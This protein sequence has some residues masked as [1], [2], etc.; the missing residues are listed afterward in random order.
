MQ[1]LDDGAIDRAL[2]DLPDW[3]REGDVLVR[4][5]RRR[6]WRHAIDLVVSVA[7][8]AEHRDHHPD[9]CVTGYRRVTFRLTTHS[10]G[11]ITDRDVALA[12][13]IDELAAP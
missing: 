5:V 3:S 4:T 12:K 9:V 6:D 2:G 13:R 7:D 10:E 1:R 11:G 8:E